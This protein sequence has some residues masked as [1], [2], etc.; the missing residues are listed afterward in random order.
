MV[1]EKDGEIVSA[2]LLRF[3]F[4]FLLT[5]VLDPVREGSEGLV[6]IKFISIQF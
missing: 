5:F 1:L 6:R 2:A 4:S 3:G